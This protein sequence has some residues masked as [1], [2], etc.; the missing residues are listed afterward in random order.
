MFSL[1]F[2]AEPQ[3]STATTSVTI[4]LEIN[5]DVHTTDAIRVLLIALSLFE[6]PEQSKAQQGTEVAF[7]NMRTGD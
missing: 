2:T 6:S 5:I 7:D 4:A 1:K 3:W